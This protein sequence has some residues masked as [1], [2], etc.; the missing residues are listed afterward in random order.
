MNVKV[1][2]FLVNVAIEN[3]PAAK[4]PEGE[5]IHRDLITRGGFNVVK[6]VRVA[7]LLRI[8]VEASN[9]AQAKQIVGSMCEELRIFNPAAHSFT[10]GV[11]GGSS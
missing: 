1:R 5:T 4:D 10:L 2:R 9:Q 11:E 3:K 7:K 6:S 8:T